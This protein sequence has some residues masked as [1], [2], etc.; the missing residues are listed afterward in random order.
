MYFPS[1]MI[2]KDPIIIWRHVRS[3][4]YA[5]IKPVRVVHVSVPSKPS[6]HRLSL[7]SAEDSLK[8]VLSIIFMAGY[9][10]KG[11]FKFYL[12][13]PL[14]NFLSVINPALTSYPL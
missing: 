10:H 9:H 5:K 3:L 11:S 12:L 2:V 8:R 13:H 7:Y 1:L 4:Y 6:G 14:Q